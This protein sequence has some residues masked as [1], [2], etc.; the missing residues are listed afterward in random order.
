MLACS[1]SSLEELPCRHSKRCK[2]SHGNSANP[3]MRY[4]GMDD[5][6]LQAVMAF[7]QINAAREL[8][9]TRCH[10]ICKSDCIAAI[11]RF[12]CFSAQTR[13]C[14][15]ACKTLPHHHT[16]CFSLDYKGSGP[17]LHHDAAR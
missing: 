16:A 12:I 14:D 5:H 10:G 11:H 1:Y 7:G 15:S 3:T 9:D 8:V 13:R 17:V 4:G 6:H 2:C